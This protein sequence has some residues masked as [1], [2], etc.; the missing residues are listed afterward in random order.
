MIESDKPEFL[1][2]L[3]GMAAMKRVDMPKEVIALWWDAMKGWEIQDFKLGAATLLRT[4]KWMPSPS[5]FED[6]K[7]QG[8]DSPGEAWAKAL[9]WAASS[10]YRNGSMGEDLID[11]CVHMLGGYKIIA[12]CEDDK[13]GFLE[14]RFSEHYE[15]LED[16][17]DVRSAVPSLAYSNPVKDPKQVA[18]TF[19]AIGK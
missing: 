1:K 10:S 16:R 8:R 2:V 11:R 4:S 7:K 18:G 12:M 14:R 5:E 19:K 15:T 17:V 6:L 13:L 3:N 9:S